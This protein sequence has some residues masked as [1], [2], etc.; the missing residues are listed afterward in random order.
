MEGASQPAPWRCP[1]VDARPS[2]HPS[3]SLSHNKPRTNHP[4]NHPPNHHQGRRKEK[5]DRLLEESRR[6]KEEEERRKKLGELDARLAEEEARLQVRWRLL[7][8]RGL[9]WGRGRDAHE[10]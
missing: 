10:P 9:G 7:V 4:I 6:E 2:T 5:E 8:L 1:D 3:L